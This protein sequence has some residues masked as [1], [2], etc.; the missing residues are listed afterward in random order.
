MAQV[1]STQSSML[2]D[3][4]A[5]QKVLQAVDG[6]QLTVPGESWLLKADFTPQGGDLLLTGHD[7]AQVLIRDF[8][9][10]DNPPD[11][12]TDAGAMIPA[13]LAS[14]L[15][16]PVAP[17]QLALV[18]GNPFSELAQ[19]AESIG[20]V[21]ATDGLVEA[22]RI[23]GT[24]VTLVKGDDV[25]QGDTLITGKGAAI[26]IT[27][28]DDTTFS[29]G[30]EG[31]MVIDEMVYDAE[32]Q[33]G[34]FSANLVQGVFSFVSGNIAKT[35][36]DGMTV[37]TPVATIGIRGTMVAG[38]A[39]QE[40]SLNS[41]SLLPE[42]DAQGNPFVGEV[43]ITTQAGTMT[44]NEAGATVQMTSAFQ[45]PPQQV[46]F[47]PQQIQ[48]SFGGALTTLTSAVAE[49]A[50]NEAA[51]GEQEA[52]QAQAEAEQAGAEAEAAAA[53]A[54]AAKAEADQAQADAEASGD[55]DAI[56]AADAKAAEA[57]AKVVEAEVK[58]ADAEAKTAEAE[59]KTAAAEVAQAGAEQANAA[60]QVQAKA[61][62]SFGGPV[63]D[64]GNNDGNKDGGIQKGGGGEQD[65]PPPPPPPPPSLPPLPPP[66]PLPPLPDSPPPDSPPPPPPPPPPGN[67]DPN[68][69]SGLVDQTPVVNS[70]FSY[71]FA[72]GTFSDSDGDALS[73]TVTLA[74]GSALPRWL[75]FDAATRTLSGTTP[76]T[77][78]APLNVMVTASDGQASVSDSFTVQVSP[79]SVTAA[80]EFLVNTTTTGNQSNPIATGLEDGGYVVFWH[81]D[82]VAST[83]YEYYGQRY[84]SAGNKVG[85]EFQVNT[86]T[87][88]DQ[89]N[90]SWTKYTSLADGGFVVSWHSNGQDTS[91]W[92]AYARIYDASGQPVAT[93]FQVNKVYAN[94]QSTISSTQLSNGDIVFS[95]HSVAQDGSTYGAYA[96]VFDVDGTPKGNEFILN[97]TT[98]DSQ[99]QALTSAL[100]NGGFVAVWHSNLQDGSG[101]AVI[102]RVFDSSGTATGNEF[103]VNTYTTLDQAYP[104]VVTLTNGGFVVIWASFGQDEAGNW[105]IYGQRYDSAGTALGTE[106]RANTTT[107]NGQGSQDIVA[108]DGGGF[109]V[110]W[111]SLGGQDG[112][113]SGMFLQRYDANGVAQGAETQVNTYT[114]GDQT[115]ANIAALEDGGFVVSWSSYGQDA[116]ATWGIYGQRYDA[117]GNAV[118]TE[119]LTGTAN[120]DAFFPATAIT[121]THID[122]A[123]GIDSLTLADATNL[124]TVSNTE[125]ITG[126]T[127]KDYV[128][129]GAAQASGSIDLGAGADVL[130]LADGTNSVSVANV[131]K[132]YGGS[133]ADTIVNTG[134]IANTIY[135]A[136]GNDTITGGTGNDTIDGGAGIDTA[137]FAGAH[138]G[139][140]LGINSASGTITV[141]DTATT[142]SGDDGS[143]SVTNVENLQ[144]ADATLSVSHAVG[145][146]RVNTT[147]AGNQDSA[148]MIATKDGG[149]VVVFDSP[150]TFGSGIFG[151][152]YD[153]AGNTL[154]AEFQINTTDTAT[155]TEQYLST[156]AKL[157]GLANGGFVVAWHSYQQDAVDGGWAAMTRIYDATGAAVTGE[158][159]LNTTT[160]GEQ[161]HVSVVQLTG[162]NLI[163]SWQS[164]ASGFYDVYGLRM[165]AEGVAVG[166]E[167]LMNATTANHQFQPTLVAQSGGGFAAFWSSNAQTGGNGSY[168]VIG[169]MYDSAATKVGG[170]FQVNTNIVN[171]QAWSQASELTSGNMVVAW[172]SIAQDGSAGGTYAQI[173]NSSGAKVGSEFRM[174]TTTSGEQGA[175]YLAALTGGGFVATWH[176]AAGGGYYN[177]S[178][179]MFDASG[180]KV[181]T[182]FHANT[183]QTNSQTW[184]NIDALEDGG[185][186]ISWQ[187]LGQDVAATEGIYTQRYDAAGNEVGATTLTG[188]AS[189]ES[190]VL[191][192]GVTATHIDLAGGAD[193]LTLA[194]ATNALSV[195]NVETI[196]GGTGNDFVTLGVAQAAGSVDLG[197]GTDV[198]RLADG[199]NTLSVANVETIYGGTGA[200]IL[201]VSG[202]AAVNFQGFAGNDTITISGSVGATITG[203]TGNDTLN[204]GTGADTFIYTATTLNSGDMAT[205]ATDTTNAAAGDIIDMTAAMEGLLS[206]GGTL[207]SA[208]TA[209]TA[210]GTALDASNSIALVDIGGGNMQIHV[211]NNA[212]YTVDFTIDVADTVT[213]AT[214]DFS[215]DHI[216]LS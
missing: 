212:D 29:L 132:I 150:D 141:T 154:G 209:N 121:N 134:T 128:T 3:Q 151:Q 194:N 40:G 157:T 167:F 92:G 156:Y 139:Y 94:E 32:T 22:V 109:V 168:E 39:S 113:G 166:G 5:S 136:A 142:T 198:L 153:V 203:G 75:T 101:H 210:L 50:N 27:F 195:A 65:T 106:F 122:L 137:I 116:T 33:E 64:S 15:A 117:A 55:P 184:P 48:Q 89:A 214:Y 8:F 21:E 144:F 171:D 88:L 58:A 73:Y 155:V 175:P 146:F 63:G 174:N 162:G 46:I 91:G 83:N 149:Y 67:T 211:D 104:D 99:A 206:T 11:L 77:I 125:T 177:I 6:G 172:Y 158:I 51:K 215:A 159:Q 202:T 165:T 53:E 72:A 147:T 145:E 56:A 70:A 38:Q 30:E 108:L 79:T 84:D 190:I 131:E 17:G 31:R 152:R 140:S 169:Q 164:G 47:S 191:D 148:Q 98:A 173:L 37:S 96:R 130:K 80:G 114:A 59:T 35:S 170:E 93:E 207:L 126:G 118:G 213:T 119:T 95:W 133:G 12:L 76:G 19:A 69:G 62:A 16:G 196:T 74:D 49:K 143:D 61:F 183:Y 200:D 127:G 181:G 87:T 179:Q 111:V 28:V 54:E 26:G 100:G 24:K 68:I 2:S 9:N 97:Q 10:L 197:A 160:T 138:T 161:A 185:F 120:N 186:V 20:R 82:H 18:D 52:A 14:K 7:G 85:S 180:A 36:P 204:G 112:S 135:S 42:M 188:T 41:F 199:G 189:N 43:S 105:G 66:L 90:S 178:A 176:D 124:L 103:Q 78:A 57:E 44:M 107:A 193:S 216:V 45:P 1:D 163:Y 25:F 71:Q 13:D 187:S 205:M 60:M 34:Q 123:G 182:E 201:S 115:P 129:L 208:L 102:G 81:S 23:D 192:A 110:S 86:Y 4:D